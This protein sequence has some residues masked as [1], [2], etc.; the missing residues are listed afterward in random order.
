[1]LQKGFSPAS[2]PACPHI[3]GAPERWGC[4]GMRRC[5]LGRVPSWQVQELGVL[6]SSLAAAGEEQ[7]EAKV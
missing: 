2:L 7:G 5:H 1:M 6:W 4:A 3:S